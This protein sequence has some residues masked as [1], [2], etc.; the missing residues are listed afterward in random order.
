[1]EVDNTGQLQLNMKADSDW[2]E[3]FGL[4]GIQFVNSTLNAV[5]EPGLPI[6]MFGK[7]FLQFHGF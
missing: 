3:P 6:P 4:K 5:F 2:K 1:M 7:F